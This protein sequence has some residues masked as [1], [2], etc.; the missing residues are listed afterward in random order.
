MAIYKI[1][2]E[3]LPDG[4]FWNCSFLEERGEFARRNA[5]N[6]RSE[7]KASDFTE[8]FLSGGKGN[9]YNPG[10]P[11]IYNIATLEGIKTS[12]E[13]RGVEFEYHNTASIDDHFGASRN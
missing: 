9:T 2:C 4:N 6:Y 8:A 13:S 10:Y 12:I 5:I 3:Y 1:I 7:H 11:S